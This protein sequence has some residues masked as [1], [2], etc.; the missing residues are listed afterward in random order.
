VV[1]QLH[2]V[3]VVVTGG[4]ICV[5]S[6]VSGLP[7]AANLGLSCHPR[8]IGSRGWRSPP[9][10]GFPAAGACCVV[11]C[12]LYLADASTEWHTCVPTHAGYALP[13]RV[14]LGRATGC[15]ASGQNVNDRLEGSRLLRAWTMSSRYEAWVAR[16]VAISA[17]N[18]RAS[19]CC[20]VRAE[21]FSSDSSSS[22]ADGVDPDA[23][24]DA[25]PEASFPMVLA[26]G[27]VAGSSSR[28][29]PS[30]AG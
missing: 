29:V 10:C 8:G 9:D 25:V 2:S 22:L 13:V 26:S 4:G 3:D 11:A 16:V 18:F 19:F 30:D 20:R 5:P 14:Q 7:S 1:G 6:A 24:P 12:W 15:V 23:V 28:I 27:G 17:R 21:G